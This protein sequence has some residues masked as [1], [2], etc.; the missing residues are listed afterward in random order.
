MLSSSRAYDFKPDVIGQEGAVRIL[1][2]VLKSGK[3]NHA[4][5]FVG[6]EG[7][8]KRYLATKF[9]S[10]LNCD[11]P[12]I[13]PCGKCLPCT[14][15]E[16]SNHPDVKVI[17]PDSGS[18]KIDQIRELKKELR[19]EPFEGR[20]RVFIIP[21]C[22]AL[23]EQA[24]N[25]LL[26][27]LESPPE[28]TVF[29]L[30][31]S[32]EEALL[33][34][35]VSRCQKVRFGKATNME[36]ETFLHERHGVP[37]ARARAIAATAGGIVGKAVSWSSEDAPL[38]FRARVLSLLRGIPGAQL[39]DILEA[40]ASFEKC[41]REDLDI[42][43]DAMLAWY[44]DLMLVAGTGKTSGIINTDMSGELAQLAPR[45]DMSAL[46]NAIGIVEDTRVAIHGNANV[47]L[48]L[49][50]MFLRLYKALEVI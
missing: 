39:S 33:P 4:Y 27:A 45:F 1:S 22:E 12:V 26:V 31:A 17:V 2:R 29:I 14:K 19:Y 5:L 41:G 40:A 16:N 38:E 13:R 11:D 46:V 15:I 34:T 32:N 50:S 20:F 43:F 28:R 21:D 37:V 24:A 10:A 48:A 23:T 3:V 18:L 47:R 44:R 7:V 42:L 9:A 6:P 30:T 49:E 35:I 8:G 25:S 36:I